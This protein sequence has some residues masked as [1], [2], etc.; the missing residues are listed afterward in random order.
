[1]FVQQFFVK[2][3]AHSSYLL[4]GTSSCAI[5]DPRRDTDIYIEAARTM[6]MNITH[7]LETHLHAD[8]ISGHIDLAA[9]TGAQIYAPRA[10]KCAFKHRPVK[11]GDSFD[12]DDMTIRVIETPGHTP[13][14]VSY[15]IIDRT[16]GSDPVAVFS[17]DTLFVG[18]V[19]RPDLFPAIA[20][21]LAA[22]LHDSLHKKLLTL[23]PF[24]TVYPAHGAGSLCGR[25]MG[26]M[27]TTTIGYEKKYNGALKIRDKK[28]FITTLTTNM[29]PAPDHFSRCSAINGKGPARVTKLPTPAMLE[30][31][32][33]KK[34]LKKK[35]TIVLDCRSTAAFGGAHIPGCFHIDFGSNFSTFAGWILP[36]DSNILL[37]PETPE[38]AGEAA[39]Q[40]RRVGHDR[41]VGFLDGGIYA[42]SKAGL[43]IDTVPQI[44]IQQLQKQMKRLERFTLLDV[45]M[46]A[47]F[48]AGHIEGAVNIA[49]PELRT[50]FNEVNAGMP[51]I[52]ICNTGHRSSMAASLL[53]KHGFKHVANVAGGMT[54]WSAAGL[55]K[56]CATCIQLHGPRS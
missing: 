52:V 40:L 7:I 31:L 14:H 44:S 1:M 29:P 36:P 33:F 11:E 42:W 48:Q 13:E 16:R 39:V 54:A 12:L 50:R 41:I 27:R 45:R 15:V 23:P 26:A 2:G 8:F 43:P 25:A 46:P 10:G 6:G 9:Q 4:G 19:G 49:M 21:K 35:N 51:V 22:Q 3:L 55:S 28:T 34:A 53:Q 32:A 24:C 56:P 5:I 38:L 30:A 18:D 20:T 47:E 37:V 17:G